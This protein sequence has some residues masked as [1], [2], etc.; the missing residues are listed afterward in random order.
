MAEMKQVSAR[1]DAELLRRFKAAV[2]LDGQRMQDAIAEAIDR[3]TKRRVR[4][5]GKEE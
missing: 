1:V 5:Q 3:D 4:L 2:A